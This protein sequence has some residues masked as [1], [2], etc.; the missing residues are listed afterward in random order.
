MNAIGPI[1][2]EV[3]A[4]E[5]QMAKEAA[6]AVKKA[7]DMD[8]FSS[9]LDRCVAYFSFFVFSYLQK[10]YGYF[11]LSFLWCRIDSNAKQ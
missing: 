2:A 6:E 5:K 1:N 10:S 11:L 4:R 9:L 8:A 3:A 7:E